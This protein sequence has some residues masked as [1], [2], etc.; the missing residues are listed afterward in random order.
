MPERP[1]SPIQPANPRPL[2]L[3]S[4]LT[5]RRLVHAGTGVGAAL[6]LSG[7]VGGSDPTPTQVPPTQPPTT[8]PEPAVAPTEAPATPEAARGIQGQ[9]AIPDGSALVVSPRLPLGGVGSAQAT[10][11]LAGEV[12]DWRDAG[13]PVSLPVEPLGEIGPD[14]YDDAVEQLD[15]GLS[16]L[17]AATG[18]VASVPLAAVDFRVNVLSIDG[19]DPLRD[20]TEGEHGPIFRVGITGDIVPGRNI[21]LTMERYGDFQYPFRR[22]ADRLAGF[23]LTIVNLEGN[24]SDTL[25]NPVYSRPNT[26]D[27]VTGTAFLEG[28]ALAGVDAVSLANNH[29]CF[30]EI[31][32]G[33]QALEDTMAALTD[34]GIPYFGAGYEIEEARAPFVTEVN[35][36]SIAVLGHD[37]VTANLDISQNR[38][39]G[40]VAQTWGASASAPGTNPFGLGQFLAD[41]ESAAAQY[42]IVIPYL[43]GGAEFKWVVP[44]WLQA[45]ARGAIDAGATLVVTNHPHIIQGMEVYAGR[46][47]VYSL[48]NF[49]FDQ[50]FSVDTRQGLIL[51]LTFDGPILVGLRLGGVEILDFC[52]PRPMSA[53]EQAAIMDRFW[54]STDR[55]ASREDVAG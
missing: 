6:A 30:N 22:I 19:R 17:D 39:L 41:V 23:D 3:P 31:G 50:M 48:G 26:I 14:G 12:A 10:A 27:F 43:H 1:N 18:R 5:R 29:S 40:V 33:T 34:S 25:E 7:C 13:A 37:A 44:E 2:V 49:I 8:P 54:R 15:A 38:D 55:L 36:V 28:F 4:R 21:H 46:P 20:R 47:I 16:D 42:D 35:G 24:V 45:A 52:Q 9:P 32:W 51:D 11:L 53:P